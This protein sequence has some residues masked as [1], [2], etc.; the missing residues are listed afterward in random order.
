MIHPPKNN[1]VRAGDVVF[2]IDTAPGVTLL[3]GPGFI[4]IRIKA[5]PQDGHRLFTHHI[6]AQEFL[7]PRRLN[8]Y[9][10]ILGSFFQ[11]FRSL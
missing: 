1:N 6:T 2:D 4:Y 9:T 7:Q 8:I 5:E 10:E 11:S 3:T